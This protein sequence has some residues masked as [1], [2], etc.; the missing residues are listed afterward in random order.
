MQMKSVAA[1]GCH[2]VSSWALCWRVD[3]AGGA[4]ADERPCSCAAAAAASGA[5][6]FPL[7]TVLRVCCMHAR[8]PV[9]GE[10]C[11]NCQRHWEC[12]QLMAMVSLHRRITL[13]FAIAHP[14]ELLLLQ[15]TYMGSPQQG[16]FAL[17]WGALC[18]LA[19]GSWLIL[20]C[21]PAPAKDGLQCVAC[22]GAAF[23]PAHSGWTTD[24][25]VP[26]HCCCTVCEQSS[27]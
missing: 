2:A 26:W 17:P 16:I 21:C 23:K 15:L 18:T 9:R 14:K 7:C 12:N 4:A 10:L 19:W 8:P 24:C 25:T 27:M 20:C 11:H 3:C 6:R 1:D 13:H 5:C 22:G